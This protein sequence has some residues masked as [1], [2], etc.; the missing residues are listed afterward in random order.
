M[1]KNLS[2]FKIQVST[3]SSKYA[4]P[5]VCLIIG[6]CSLLMITIASCFNSELEDC[7]CQIKN[8][9]DFFNDPL[10]SF[11]FQVLFSP[12]TC[13]KLKSLLE[14]SFCNNLSSLPD[15]HS[16]FHL[17][18]LADNVDFTDKYGAHSCILMFDADIY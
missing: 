7:S 13:W 11:L 18:A 15:G 2:K 1:V 3:F 16:S 9:K 6:R 5:G 14:F 10:S 12:Y 4:G 17:I 8:E